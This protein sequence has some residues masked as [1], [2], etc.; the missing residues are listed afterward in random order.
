MSSGLTNIGM[1][2][3]SKMSHHFYM[4]H[5]YL[6]LV[7]I[8]TLC[9]A[10]ASADIPS[11]ASYRS[12][13]S[14][15]AFSYD[16][17]STEPLI[18]YRHVDHMIAYDQ[19]RPRVQIF[20]DGRVLVHQP[21]YMKDAGD[22]EMRLSE[23]ELN[24]L[25]NAFSNN[26]MMDFDRNSIAVKKKDYVN[27]MQRLTGRFRHISDTV[28]TR[29]DI[30][31]KSFKADR[32]AAQLEAFSKTF[33]HDNIEQDARYFSGIAEIQKAAASVQSL[34]TLMD[35]TVRSGNHASQ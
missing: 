9:P 12:N 17:N 33:S 31:L 26:G 28:T 25:I 11:I 10:V 13:S 5:T 1:E 3:H 32:Q 15:L 20:G 19:D 2:L 29:V 35:Q 14:G 30:R 34:R 18:S 4:L 22:Y 16:R 27:R 23:T 24:L 21:V 6:V 7:L 8:S